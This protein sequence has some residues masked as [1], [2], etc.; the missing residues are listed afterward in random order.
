MTKAPLLLGLVT[1]IG[2]WLLR[3]DATT[4][5]KGSIKTI[6]GFMLVQVGAGTL[7]AGFKPVI[8]KLSEYHG[9]TGSVIDPYTSMMSTMEAMGDNYSWVGYAVLL[10]L[11]INILLVLFRRYT[12]IRTIMLTG[13]IMF[14]AS[15]SDRRVL[16]CAWRKHVG[17]HHLLCGVNGA[18]LGYLLQHHVQAN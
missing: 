16:L 2:Y 1:C 5:I 7:V 10:A 11:G 3:R 9:L 12:G 14:P 13:H 17:N 15:G 4:I 8:S 6:V 18:V